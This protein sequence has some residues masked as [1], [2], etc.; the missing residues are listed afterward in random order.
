[1]N[2]TPHLVNCVR[3]E[4]VKFHFFQY[5]FEI[6]AIIIVSVA[7]AKWENTINRVDIIKRIR[8]V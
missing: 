1:M 2:E 6:S 3:W 5:V 7:L 4:R 8:V